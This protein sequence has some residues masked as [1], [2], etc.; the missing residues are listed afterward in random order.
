MAGGYLAGLIL[1]LPLA[2]HRVAQGLGWYVFYLADPGFQWLWGTAAQLGAG[3]QFYAGA[4][5]GRRR[6]LAVAL[7]ALALYGY[8]VAALLMNRQGSRLPLCFDFAAAIV[9]V[10]GGVA[11]L[12]GWRRKPE[13]HA[14]STE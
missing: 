5:R 7:P 8:S 4:V 12:V 1:A 3:W 10:A 11:A 2:A 13:G 14:G 6:D 9:V